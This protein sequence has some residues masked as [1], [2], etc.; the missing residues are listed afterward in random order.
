MSINGGTAVITTR[1]VATLSPGEDLYYLTSEGSFSDPRF[2]QVPA[3]RTVSQYSIL[4]NLP[5]KTLAPLITTAARVRVRLGAAV[6]GTDHA[7][8]GQ[9]PGAPE[10]P[11]AGVLARG[12]VQARDGGTVLGSP[13]A[14]T[15][16]SYQKVVEAVGVPWSVLSDREFPVDYEGTLPNFGSLEPGSFPV[17][18]VT[19]DFFPS[20][21]ESG[22]GVLIVTGDLGIPA[23]SGWQWKGIVMAG[24]LRDFGP[25]ANFL[26]EGMLVAGQGSPMNNWDMDNGRIL[27]HSC[28]AS[29]AG[30]A[31]AHLSAVNG[32]W[33]ERR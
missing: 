8:P 2:P 33:W 13:P 15:L 29:W 24:G 11:W 18:R 14:L 1:K 23:N 10:D 6:D 28:Y 27:Y 22:Q 12:A 32:G 26:L 16:G 19:G 3:V 9:C 17:I 4:K 7:L 20:A 5:V 31:L 30:A 21:A 25:E